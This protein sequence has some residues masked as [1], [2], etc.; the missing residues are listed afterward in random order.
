MA[1]A[2]EAARAYGHARHIAGAIGTRLAGSDADA[3][4]AHFL[5]EAFEAAGLSVQE[6][7][8][9]ILT[10]A[11]SAHKLE[12][13][14]PTRREATCAPFVLAGTT[15]DEGVV[16]APF[17]IGPGHRF[18]GAE[19]KI[20]FWRL[21]SRTELLLRFD[22]LAAQRPLAVVVLWPS[23]GD[24][25][26][27]QRVSEARARS[28]GAPPSLAIRREEGDALA[29]AQP[30]LVRVLLKGT[31]AESA[32]RNV[33]AELPGD[34]R[35]E[36]VIVVGA[37]MD[38]APVAA[39]A[40]DNA[41]GLAITLELATVFAAS[42]SRRTLRFVG[43]GAEKAGMV[44]SRR[45]VEALSAAERA[46][47]RLCISI[48]GVGAALGKLVCYR[49]GCEALQQAVR[50]A[51]EN[52]CAGVEV[53]AGFYGTD[54]EMFVQAGVPAL[55]FGQEGPALSYLHT[56]EDNLAKID[57]TRLGVAGRCVEQVLRAADASPA[58]P[59]APSVQSQDR[60]FATT[61]LR[62]MGWL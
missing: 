30:S 59:F 46:A 29:Q 24:L 31:T 12:V 34:E 28:G 26:K 45:Y 2:F 22:E 36:E 33:I 16:G 13:L 1:S 19:G 55:S 62:Q 35:P 11:V 10:G 47:H 6:R 32:S 21:G 27:H 49:V 18:E 5:H 23:A 40:I 3:R 25:P 15:P 17:W 44:G 50:D 38:T 42:G 8:F 39:G 54:S 57:P 51:S 58:W 60:A 52:A 37:H 14:S 61:L 43:W 48:D 4:T 41:S 56:E 9:P 53:R 7:T 20:A